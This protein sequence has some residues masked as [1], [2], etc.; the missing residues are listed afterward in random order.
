M[1]TMHGRFGIFTFILTLLF[2]LSGIRFSQQNKRLRQTTSDFNK[3]IEQ[4]Q[5]LE[6]QNIALK[7]RLTHNKDILGELSNYLILPKSETSDSTIEVY[8]PETQ[9]N[10]SIYQ[11]YLT[12]FI[13]YDDCVKVLE[14]LCETQLPILITSLSIHRNI[15][16]NYA[17][18]ISMAY[19]TR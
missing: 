15:A 3:T 19:R 7:K 16:H 18:Q 11:N 13:A 17:L 2:L 6:T 8:D 1:K 9:R 10:I 5:Y 4:E 12:G 14:K